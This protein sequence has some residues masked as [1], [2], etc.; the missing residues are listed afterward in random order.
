MEAVGPVNIRRIEDPGEMFHVEQSQSQEPKLLPLLIKLGI[1]REDEGG[2]MCPMFASMHAGVA[3]FRSPAQ[4]GGDMRKFKQD[5][6][7]VEGEALAQA[8][9]IR[10]DKFF[11]KDGKPLEG[12][13]PRKAV[14]VIR[15]IDNALFLK[16]RE[17]IAYTPTLIANAVELIRGM[18][19][20][21]FKSALT[22]LASN[23]QHPA[24][25]GLTTERILPEFKIYLAKLPR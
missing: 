16:E 4:R 13:E 11:D 8:Q 19:E 9:L 24:I 15:C 17:Q 6:A 18:D 21:Q 22:L 2:Y 7:R 10:A 14:W 20:G 25:Q 3:A 12:E 5:M 23:R 1:L